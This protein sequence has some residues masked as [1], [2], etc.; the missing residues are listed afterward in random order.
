M[1]N[2]FKE[3]WETYVQSWKVESAEEKHALLKKCMASNSQYCDPAI[4]TNNKEELVNYMLDFHQQIPGGH[5][6]TQYFLAH[7]NKSI[8]R[9]EMRNA[10][11]DLLGDGISYA[12]YND[13]GMLISETGFFELPEG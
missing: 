5:F 3:I 12:E 13:D 11:N 10:N 4:T 2:N 9:W 8:A 6:V 1:S 7:H